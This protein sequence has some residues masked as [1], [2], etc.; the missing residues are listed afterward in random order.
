MRERFLIGQPTWLDLL[1]LPFALAW[2]KWRGRAG[3]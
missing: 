1:A 3:T 2:E